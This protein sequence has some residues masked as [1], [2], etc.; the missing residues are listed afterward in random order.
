MKERVIAKRYARAIFELAVE[1]KSLDAASRDMQALHGAV[2]A[3]PV[4]IEALSDERCD[5][6][7]RAAAAGA[8]AKVLGLSRD[9][10]NALKLIVQ[11][12]RASLIPLIAE[13]FASRAE[14][15]AEIMAI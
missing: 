10:E 2:N 6:E 9:T 3:Q 13:D 12:G 11:K 7:K 5:I 14:R 4:I 15:Y 1:G 8:I